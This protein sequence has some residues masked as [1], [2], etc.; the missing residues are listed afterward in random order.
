V[1]PVRAGLP[2]PCRKTPGDYFVIKPILCS[3]ALALLI[4]PPGRTARAPWLDHGCL[5]HAKGT[6]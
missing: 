4:L 2:R 1:P 6:E 3:T 5:S